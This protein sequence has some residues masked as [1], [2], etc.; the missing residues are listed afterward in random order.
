MRD[1]V[2]PGTRALAQSHLDQA[3]RVWLVT[4]APV[5]VATIIAKRL[6]LT[7]ALGT[8]AEHVDGVYTGRL[9]GE[10]L[11]GPAK[12]EAVRALATR[13]DLE[14]ELCSAYSDSANDIPMLS[15]VGY[16]CAVNPDSALRAHARQH[17]W[18]IR[19]YRARRRRAVGVAAGRRRRRRTRRPRHGA[20]PK[21]APLI[22]YRRSEEGAVAADEQR[23]Q[24][25]LDGL[26]DPVG[27]VEDQHRVLGGT[28]GWMSVGIGSPNS[29]IHLDGRGTSP[30][31][32]PGERRV[33]P[34]RRA[35]GGGRGRPGCR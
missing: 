14:L 8:V 5:E 22:S 9:V 25:L 31:P 32:E 12:A 20:P 10:L 1:K 29:M 3:Q 21:P 30:R 27:E 7:G 17:G 28:A 13:E 33:S 18:R 24:R 6:G 34:A 16:P 19:D 23:V 26:A 35:P 15:L 2:W 11:H 4:A